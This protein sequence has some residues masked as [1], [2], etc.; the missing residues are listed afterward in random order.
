M[1]L[2]YALMIASTILVYMTS[3]VAGQEQEL[4]GAKQAPAGMAMWGLNSA[5]H[6]VI[7]PPTEK[8]SHP[9]RGIPYAVTVPVWK[10]P[11]A[12]GYFGAKQRH[13]RPYRSFGHQ[14]SY[15]QWRLR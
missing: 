8:D 11:Y 7:Q 15:T 9:P 5:P 12:Y 1:G 4:V 13:C 10:Q 3:G 14:Q 6:L 2:K